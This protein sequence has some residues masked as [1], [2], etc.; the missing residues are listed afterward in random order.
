MNEEKQI[1]G[2]L[3]KLPLDKRDFSLG[4]VFG[5]FDLP[6]DI[7]FTV[8]TPLKI[9]DQGRSD[10]RCTAYA[11]CAVSEDQE[12]VEL[13]PDYTFAKT[14]QIM[15]EFESW[16]ADLRA[17]LKSAVISKG[18]GFIKQMTFNDDLS[19]ETKLKNL[20]DWNNWPAYLDELAKVNAKQSFFFIKTFGY[21]D[22]FDAIRASLYHFRNK[23]QS[24]I[25]GLIWCSEWTRS[26]DGVIRKI[27]TPSFG[28]AFKIYGQRMIHGEPFLIA[29]LSNGDIGDNGIFYMSREVVNAVE[30]FGAG[31]LVDLS[32]EHAETLIKHDWTVNLLWLAKFLV[33]LK[34]YFKEIFIK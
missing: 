24:I 17:A 20:R 9:K 4:G 13:N 27:G 22:I 16:G 12:G 32:R 28:H 7:D 29:Q 26:K 21:R 8:S 6:P 1:F 14:K 10:D 25:T 15:G 34:K 18:Y 33:V 31:M 2:G 5:Q 3:S 23:N 11:L 19:I 30:D